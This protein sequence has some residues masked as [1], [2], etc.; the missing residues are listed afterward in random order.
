M[1]NRGRE[2]HKRGRFFEEYDDVKKP[3]SRPGF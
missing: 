3:G 1:T 2:T